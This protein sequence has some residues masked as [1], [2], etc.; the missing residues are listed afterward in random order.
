METGWRPCL[1]PGLWAYVQINAGA[2]ESTLSHVEMRYGGW[3]RTSSSTDRAYMLW[4]NGSSPVISDC[5]FRD[6]YNF[7]VY[8]DT[9]AREI[10]SVIM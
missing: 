6:F 4:A 10:I 7:G 5:V 2:V 8:F 3:Y 9:P 1:Q